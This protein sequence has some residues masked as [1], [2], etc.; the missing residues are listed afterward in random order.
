MGRKRIIDYLMALV[1]V[2]SLNFFLPRLLPGDPCYP[3]TVRMP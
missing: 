1:I 3:F 2:I